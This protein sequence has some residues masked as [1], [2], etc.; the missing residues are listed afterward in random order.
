MSISLM[1]EPPVRVG[2][3]KADRGTLGP[4]EPEPPPP[5]SVGVKFDR[6]IGASFHVN[7]EI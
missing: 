5:M 2:P 3:N 7:K 1:S 4:E 6:P